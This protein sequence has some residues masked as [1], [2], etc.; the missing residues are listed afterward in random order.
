M[1]KINWT[2]ILWTF[3]LLVFAKQINGQG[4]RQQYD[5]PDFD[6]YAFTLL[7]T[8]EGGF[9]MTGN[10][11]LK[12]DADG[13]QQWSL[14]NTPGA[15]HGSRLAAIQADGSYVTGYES[16]ALSAPALSKFDAFGN[17]LWSM[18]YP[19]AN[20]IDPYV[21]SVDTTNDGGFVLLVL[22]PGNN[23]NCSG[24]SQ[25]HLIKTD[26]NG[27]MQWQQTKATNKS[28]V[29]VSV[30][31]LDDGG[32]AVAGANEYIGGSGL[33]RYIEKW[34]AS[35]VLLWEKEWVQPGVQQFISVI[36]SSD[37][38]IVAAGIGATPGLIFM[39][40]V[41]QFGNEIWFEEYEATGLVNARDLK[42]GT[43]GSY[44]VVGHNQGGI[45][46]A[47]FILN[48]APNGI[49]NWHRIFG[50]D[51]FS[52]A[53]YSVQACPDGGYAISGSTN[54]AQG[55]A[56]LYKV[57]AL[58]NVYTHHIAG[59]VFLDEAE[60]CTLDGIEPGLENWIVTAAGDETFYASTDSNGYYDLL[61]D[62]GEYKVTVAL[63]NFS[64]LLCQPSY[65]VQALAVY[66]T[67]EL[68][69][70][71][72]PGPPCPYMEVN[73]STPFIRP[74]SLGFYVV[75]Y[76]NLGTDTAYGATVEVLLADELTYDAATIPLTSQVGQ[77]LLFDIGDVGIF[78][79][80]SFAIQFEADCDTTLVGQTLCSEAHIFPDTM[81]GPMFQGPAIEVL[82]LCENDSVKFEIL[83]NGE[84]MPEVHEYII[85]EDNI[86]LMQD[87]FQLGQG[88]S[89]ETV[90]EVMSGA[91]YHLVAA[92]DVDFPPF[93]GNPVATFSIEGCVGNPNPGAFNQL[94][95][96]SGEP[97]LDI[98]CQEVTSSYDPNDKTPHPTGWTDEHLIEARTDLEYRIRFQNTGTDTAFT[99]V[100]VDTLSHFLDPANIRP[101]AASHPYS[102]ELTGQGVAKFKFA[103]I[104]LPDSTTNEAAS[105]GF[106]SFKISQIPDNQVSTVIENTAQIYFDFNAP[107]ATNT[108]FHTIGEP[109]VSIIS[110]TVQVKDLH[111][112]VKVFP[113]P[114]F[115]TATFKLEGYAKNGTLELYD[116]NG[117]RVL[118]QNFAAGETQVQRNVLTAGIYFFKMKNADGVLATGKVVVQ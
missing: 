17:E 97:W 3:L 78:E 53:F 94:P 47:G 93:L 7:S 24:C 19:T 30:K 18:G 66:D 107:V 90:V 27:T 76:C 110:G 95:Q 116:L 13:N 39:A 28:N 26:G 37:G 22:D 9:L 84:A 117:L 34:D 33:E 8:P 62:T 50:N 56:L 46:A 6:D 100:I 52:E 98:D 40:K 105:H 64:W 77:T 82:G 79:C 118:S 108:T 65:T 43:D 109:W 68:D 48:A 21:T 55:I 87:D 36:E 4:W 11:H 103:N 14:I 102:F 35:G 29:A 1:K 23:P 74:C 112:Q 20:G 44:T 91:T 12:T 57:D 59:R 41:D 10:R 106:V 73:I 45:P 86:I 61:L 25:Y 75:N 49:E 101:G 15:R 72:Q 104:L 51:S 96:N 38:N 80:G 92:Q 5:S 111:Q 89:I 114:F 99:V 31:S 42:E 85:I 69:I 60:D 2:T 32:F 63:P 70:P 83:N 54:H 113:N 115:E 71:V 67:T 81:C 88:E 16:V 58:G